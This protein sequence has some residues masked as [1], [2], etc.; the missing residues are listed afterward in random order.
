MKNESQAHKAVDFRNLHIAE[1]IFVMPN[2]WNAGSAC[3]LETAGFRVAGTTSAGIAF[4][5]GLPDHEG[6]LSR[7][8]ALEET[9]RIAAAV[10]IPVSADAK[11]GYG[12]DPAD[13]AESVRLFADAGAVGASIEDFAASFGDSQYE[14][15]QAVDRNR[16]AKEACESLDYPFTLT[17]RSECYL[18]NHPDPFRESVVRANLYREAGGDCL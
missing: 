15:P 13:V 4:Y 6:V 14:R 17:A 8:A 10:K 5:L 3:V 2:A 1:G 18:V 7:G 12:H 9:R 11:N 16:A